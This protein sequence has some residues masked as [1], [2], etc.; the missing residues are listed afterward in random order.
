MQEGGQ[1]ETP[2]GACLQLLCEGVGALVGLHKQLQVVLQRLRARAGGGAAS[3]RS[4]AACG[5]PNR[6][7]ILR[8]PLQYCMLIATT[9]C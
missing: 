1:H 3:R 9:L 5:R 6:L 8:A 4:T 2:V 7:S